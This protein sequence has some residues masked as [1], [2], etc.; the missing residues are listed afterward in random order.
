[1][2][3]GAGFAPEPFRV[4]VPEAVLDDLRARLASTRWPTPSP[5]VPWRD[6][7]ELAY[8]QD[9]CGYWA[10]GFDWRAA[11]ARLNRWPQF[12]VTLDGQPVHYLHVRSP[13]E[14]ARPLLIVHGWP[15]SVAEFLDVVDPLVDP[16]AHGGDPA[17]AFHVVA[18]SLPG[19]GF[20]G[21]TLEPGWTSARIA[22]AFAALM[23][24]L[25]YD[26]FG[27]QGGDWG[28]TVVTALA[29]LVPE[30]LS[31]IHLNMVVVSKPRHLP[32]PM[33]GVTDDE[34][35]AMAAMHERGAEEMGYGAIQGTRP[36]TLGFGLHDSPAGLAAWIV[37]KFRAWSDCD[38]D[39]ERS[40]TRDQLLTNITIYWV[41][42]TITSSMRLYRESRLAG[43]PRDVGAR[44]QAVPMG[45][46]RFPGDGF[47]F[48]RAWVEQVYDVRHW[49][50][51]PRGGHFAAM[52]E[53]ELFVD[54]VRAFFRSL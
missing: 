39:V 48:P 33:A 47:Q 2:A 13:V 37:E 15:G 32:D 25:G 11:E 22:S 3:A 46:A 9:L 1:V 53:P 50:D 27:A 45:F 35:A 31:G 12:R 29:G 16:A 23:T 54:D 18:P 4:D 42:G 38:G 51:M 43:R 8:L 44:P 14:S 26:R 6:G 5:A 17:D 7:T 28:S 20:S 24:G 49:T 34:L 41:T 52:E 19:Y 10:S 21:P 30:R 36:Q 40:F